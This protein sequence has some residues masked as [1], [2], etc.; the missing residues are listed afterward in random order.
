MNGETM[1]RY[2]W[3][4]LGFIVG[5]TILVLSQRQKSGARVGNET[6][7]PKQSLV[8]TLIFLIESV[9]VAPTPKNDPIYYVDLSGHIN[10]KLNENLHNNEND[11][12]NLIS[13]PTGKQKLG[14]VSF[15]IG[16]GVVQLGS[17]SVEGKPKKIEGIKV[18]REAKTLHFLH[19]TG[20]ST[21]NNALIGKYIIHY[22]DKTTKEI[23]I[24][25]GK[26]VMDWWKQPDQ[27]G[28][29]EGKVA[30][31]S[32]NEASKKYHVK[33]RLYLKTWENPKPDQKI[34]SIDFVVENEE[35]TSAPFCVAIT[36]V[37]KEK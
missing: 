30:W 11:S 31:E 5:V 14:D 17:K 15:E 33:I 12:N 32:E 1:T 9:L 3:C 16:K 10:V 27:K 21:D 29:S 4:L 25:F 8:T 35:Q 22:E 20:F 6:V 36:A 23:E 7:F 2:F 18:G 19:S 26:D 13:L 24:I 34:V 28:P 37:G